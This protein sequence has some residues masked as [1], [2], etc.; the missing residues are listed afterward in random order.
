MYFQNLGT[1]IIV[2][3]KDQKKVLLG[4]RIN[5][6]KSGFYGLPGGR[7]ELEEEILSGGERELLEE[8]GLK[9]NTLKYAGVVHEKKA[10]HTFVHF[11]LICTDF[12]GEPTVVEKDKC[13]SWQWFDLQNLPEDILPGHKAALEIYLNPHPHNFKDI[14]S[15]D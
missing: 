9:A 13:Q 14:F 15:V 6:Y 5:S 2:L 10:D 3:N 12:E 8:T 11:A 4:K 1:C 7:L